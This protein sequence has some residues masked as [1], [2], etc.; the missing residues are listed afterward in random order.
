MIEPTAPSIVDFYLWLEETYGEEYVEQLAAL[1]PRIYPSSLPIGEALASGEISASPYAAPQ[2][3]EGLKAR[4]RR[5]STASAP[6]VRGA[7]ASSG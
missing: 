3:L 1:E 2:T 7:P 4:G 5:S 6:T